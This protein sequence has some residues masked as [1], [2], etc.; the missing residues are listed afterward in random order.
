M[1]NQLTSFSSE[2]LGNLTELYLSDN[3]LTS[4]SSEGL[5][6]LTELYLTGNRLRTIHVDGGLQNLRTFLRVI[7]F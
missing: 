5:G 6:N 3:Q 7:V 1:N 2:G 4:F